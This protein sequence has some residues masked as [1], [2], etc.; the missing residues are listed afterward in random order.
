[1]YSRKWGGRPRFLPPVS[2]SLAQVNSRVLSP[3]Q[4]SNR[5]PLSKL[6]ATP[7]H[8]RYRPHIST[9]SPSPPLKWA[10]SEAR[11]VRHRQVY[12]TPT[13]HAASNP[14]MNVSDKQRVPL[15]ATPHAR[16]Q[17]APGPLR[18]SAAL[19]STPLALAAATAIQ[20]L[21]TRNGA[22]LLRSSSST[23]TPK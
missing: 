3:C 10:S 20:R 16:R 23:S 17:L 11:S 19:S 7:G 14:F 12:G 6:S 9:P 13:K 2:E 8:S 15:P 1:M 22:R 4:P 5:P 18:L 21:T